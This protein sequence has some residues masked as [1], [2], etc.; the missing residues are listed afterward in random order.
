MAP[1]GMNKYCCCVVGGEVGS[2]SVNSKDKVAYD[3]KPVLTPVSSSKH[4]AK[5]CWWLAGRKD[6][7]M[8]ALC[9]H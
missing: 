4:Y 6:R 7:P 1:H 8:A 2:T 9:G 5:C 3:S